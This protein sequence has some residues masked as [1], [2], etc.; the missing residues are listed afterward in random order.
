MKIHQTCNGPCPYLPTG[1]WTTNIFYAESITNRSY[2]S[3]LEKGWRRSGCSFYYN[4]CSEC[5]SC[6]PI[7]VDVKRFC[8]NRSQK[9]TLKLNHD[10]TIERIPATFATH[11]YTLYKQYCLSRHN[12]NPTEDEY[13]HFLV[14][15]PLETEIIRY[16]TG[17]NLIAIAWIDMLPGSISSVYCAYDPA[18]AQRSPGTLSILCQIELCRT[19]QKP[20]LYLGFYVP[21]SSRMRY[22]KNFQPCQKLI[23]QQWRSP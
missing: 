8:P 23:N 1:Q 11:D 5:Q 21:E 6:I 2:E 14:Q 15:S 3:L 16:W 10:I 18:H 12:Q 20:W 7:R 19:L 17:K 4:T 9:R 13:N 22:K